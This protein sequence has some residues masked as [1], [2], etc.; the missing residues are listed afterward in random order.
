MISEKLD[1]AK[2]AFLLKSAFFCEK[3]DEQQ[4][5]MLKN[6]NGKFRQHFDLFHTIWATKKN[7]PTFH[8]T[9]WFIGILILAS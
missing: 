7:P 3:G 1:V 6:H 8:Y 4:R 9:D 2:A 5:S